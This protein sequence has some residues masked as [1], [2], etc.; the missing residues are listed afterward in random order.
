MVLEI[1]SK[2]IDNLTTFQHRVTELERFFTGVCTYVSVIDK[3]H[4]TDFVHSAKQIASADPS[5]KEEHEE[6]VAYYLKV[7]Q[8]KSE[9]LT[10]SE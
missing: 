7:C 10:Y 6:Q 1:L 9:S 3:T 8:Y 4:V 2:C 5:K